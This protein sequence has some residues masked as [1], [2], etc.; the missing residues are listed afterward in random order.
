[1]K[2]NSPKVY[3]GTA[4]IKSK[5]AASVRLKLTRRS[6]CYHHGYPR[7]HDAKRREGTKRGGKFSGGRGGERLMNKK[8]LYKLTGEPE[9]QK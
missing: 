3:L 6:P 7:I 4:E 1:M 5:M 9:A 2:C 8:F